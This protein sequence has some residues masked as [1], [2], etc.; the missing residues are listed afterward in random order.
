VKARTEKSVVRRERLRIGLLVGLVVG[1]LLG[2]VGAIAYGGMVRSQERQ[3]AGELAWGADHGTVAGPVGCNWLFR[4]TGSQLDSGSI[5]PPAGFPRRAAMERVAAGAPS[6]V[7]V[8]KANGT[9]YHVLTQARGDTVVQVVFDARY[10]IADRQ[11]LLMAFGAAALLGLLAALGTGIVVGHRAVAPLAEALERQRRFVADASHEL[12]TPIAQ[13]HTRAQLLARRARA[14]AATD[15]ADLERLMGT[16]RRLGEIVDELL[17][18]ARLAADP[19]GPARTPVDLTGLVEATVATEGDRAAEQ[20]VKLVLE[21]PD[22]PTPVI[23]VES[24]LRR[25]VAE[26]LSNALT[27]TPGGGRIT[28]TLEQ[29]G[30]EVVLAVADTGDG[31][32]PADGKRLFDRF[33]RG[34]GA[35]ERRFGI[36]LALLREVVTGHGGTI[37]AE[38][39]PGEGATFTVRLPAGPAAAGATRRGFLRRPVPVGPAS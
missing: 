39:R 28:V 26:L 21:G 18:S 16:T 14:A 38:G 3:I 31:F 27:H 13:V 17:L 29:A 15:Q 37:T 4:L 34:A 10:Q 6:S 23:G 33:H 19:S 20:D 5:T 32:D 22:A 12:R 1:L 9:T 11:H 24:A 8:L 7:V 2:V 36:G 25:V 30:P 35:G